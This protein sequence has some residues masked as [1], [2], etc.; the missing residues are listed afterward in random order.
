ML[1]A[2]KVSFSYG[3]RTVVDNVSLAVE[4]GKVIAILGPNGAGK[5]SLFRLLSGGEEPEEGTVTLDGKPLKSFAAEALAR[6]RSVLPQTSQLGFNFTV[7]E[8]VEMGRL[9]HARVDKS[10]DEEAV[11]EQAMAQ[12][13]IGNFAERHFLSLSGGERQ[14]VHLARCLAQVWPGDSTPAESRYLLLDEPTN[15]LDISHQHTCLRE[16]RLLATKGVGVA[17]ILHDFNLALAYADTC[18]VLFD[19]MVR[20]SGTVATALTA[21]VISDVFGVEAT[22]IEHEGQRVL[23]TLARPD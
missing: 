16:A 5:T 7:R 3:R 23:V 20:A 21:E 17:C 13:D 6:R 14:R 8:V 12:A 1:C 15:N 10:V 11:V 9:P 22:M 2:D 19:G 4:P 18:V